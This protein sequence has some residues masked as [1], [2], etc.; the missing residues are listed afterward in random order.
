[1]EAFTPT[2]EEFEGVPFRVIPE[3]KKYNTVKK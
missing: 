3:D 1:M 2:Q